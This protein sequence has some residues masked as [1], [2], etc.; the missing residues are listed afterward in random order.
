LDIVNCEGK[1]ELLSAD[2]MINIKTKDNES[3][4]EKEDF[5]IVKIELRKELAEKKKYPCC[6]CDYQANS[7]SDLVVHRK[8]LH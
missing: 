6:F 5:D 4:K 2:S 8:V 3:V 1:V 7:R